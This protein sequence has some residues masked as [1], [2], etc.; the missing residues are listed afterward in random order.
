MPHS[1]LEIFP[2]PAFRDNYIWLIKRGVHAAVVDPGD[3]APVQQVLKRLSLELSAILITH[4][5]SD[6]IGG[7]AELLG[8]WPARVYAPK[9]GQYDFPHEPVG[10]HDLVKLEALGLELTV[11][12]LP[13]HT[14]DHVAYY[15]ADSIFCGDT[16]FAAGCGRLFEGT[17]AQMFAS[18]Q[19]L[20]NLPPD[21]AVYCTHEYTEHNIRFARTLEP[22][23]AALAQRQRLAAV[24]RQHGQPTLPSSIALELETNPFLRCHTSAVQLS[25]GKKN[26]DPLDVF[27]AIRE[28]RNH[29]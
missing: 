21:T 11:M 15:G 8:L 20:A 27:S 3:A 14:L 25:A 23:N 10:E 9:H 12:E 7:V 17:P 16:L 4:H 24:T 13:G 18:L 2:I 5:H 1:D 6:H 29:Y 22:D 28:L 19:R 26:A